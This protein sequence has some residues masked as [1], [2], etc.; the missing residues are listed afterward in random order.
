MGG[1]LSGM[2]MLIGNLQMMEATL[3]S[4]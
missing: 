1:I 3:W 4:N 2:M